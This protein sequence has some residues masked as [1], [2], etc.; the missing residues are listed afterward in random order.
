[1]NIYLNK[2]ILFRADASI[3]LGNGHIMR[4][5]TLA[6]EFKAQGAQCDFICRKHAGDAIDF[7]RNH[8]FPVHVLPKQ[9][10]QQ[11]DENLDASDLCVYLSDHKPDLIIVDHYKLGSKW[12]T[13]TIK[14]CKKLVV[15]DDLANREH[16]CDI[17]I[18]QGLNCKKEDYFHLVDKQ[19]NLLVGQKYG[20]LRKEFAQ[21]R[22]YSLKRRDDPTVQHILIT[23]GGTDEP[24]ATGQV[25]D[26]LIHCNLPENCLITV[27]MG[28]KAPWLSTI[29]CLAKQLAWSTQVLVDVSNIAALMAESDIAI[30]AVGGTA[31]ERCCLGLPT[32]MIVLADNQK[33]G[34]NALAACGAAK[35]IGP[36]EKIQHNL[37]NVLDTFIANPHLLQKMWENAR[38]ITDGHGVQNIIAEVGDII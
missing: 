8:G 23:M 1:M 6:N 16:N 32:L 12:E 3:T 28:S 26:A 29:K 36:A 5:L 19:C 10:S 34:A 38:A 21:L 25:L 17:L 30:G 20:I 4:C 2:K 15:I 31:W 24:N 13:K 37:P 11:L 22:S 9:I 27:V 14:Y 33:T 18:D 35:L 7:I